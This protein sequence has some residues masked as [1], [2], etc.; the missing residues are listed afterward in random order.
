MTLARPAPFVVF[1]LT[2]AAGNEG[3]CASRSVTAI[4]TTT[5]A[6]AKRRR[7]SVLRGLRDAVDHHDVDRGAA[8][9][10]PEAKLLANRS[11][12]RGRIPRHRRAVD[13]RRT[14]VGQ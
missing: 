1:G 12:Q 8:R 9:V 13:L 14:D 4:R 2:D 6:T 11:S 5:P 7:T 3:C 10:D